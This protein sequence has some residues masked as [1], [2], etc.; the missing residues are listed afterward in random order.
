MDKK[1][2]ISAEKCAQIVSLNTTKLSEH[3]I[4]R[5]MKVSKFVVHNAIKKFQKVGTFMDSKRSGRR[6]ISSIRDDR[7]IRKV[8]S[9]SPMSSDKKMQ[10]GIAERGI[11]ISEK[12]IRRRLSVDFG[13]NTIIPDDGNPSST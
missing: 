9:Q 6:R 11:K 1:L 4:S 12:T 7:V 13:H 2:A 5:Q 10:A 3:E 8:V